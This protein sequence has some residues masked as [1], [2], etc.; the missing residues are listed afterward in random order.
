[1]SPFIDVIQFSPSTWFIVIYQLLHHN[2]SWS[3]TCS[4]AYMDSCLM[5]CKLKFAFIIWHLMKMIFE[6][7]LKKM[8]CHA[9]ITRTPH[10]EIYFSYICIYKKFNYILI[11]KEWKNSEQNS[12][13]NDD[14]LSDIC[15]LL[16]RNSLKIYD[17]NINRHEFVTNFLVHIMTTWVHARIRYNISWNFL[18]WYLCSLK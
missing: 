5:T 1:M 7:C 2:R 12:E 15:W 8:H 4:F 17:S 3:F 9:N 13:Y 11:S 14:V 6:N 16:Q 18:L 10:M